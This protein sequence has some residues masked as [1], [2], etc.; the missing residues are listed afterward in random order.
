MLRTV[1]GLNTHD[2][3]SKSLKPM[4][5]SGSGPLDVR[6]RPNFLQ[7]LLYCPSSRSLLHPT[8]ETDSQV[9]ASLHTPQHGIGSLVDRTG[10]GRPT[11]SALALSALCL[12]P[13]VPIQ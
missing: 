13:L 2:I 1:T 8:T 5:M 11:L 4:T 7:S 6:D 3:P 9:F 12:L 10:S